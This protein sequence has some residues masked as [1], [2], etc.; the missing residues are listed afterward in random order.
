MI[1]QKER[2][3]IKERCGACTNPLPKKE[4]VSELTLSV[5]T[6]ERG[7]WQRRRKYLKLCKG[8]TSKLVEGLYG[9]K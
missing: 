9:K 6:N 3:A 1:T 5:V 8:C 2:V 7:T 4:A